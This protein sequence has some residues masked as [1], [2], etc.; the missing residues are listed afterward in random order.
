MT[1]ESA[2]VKAAGAFVPLFW[3]MGL[4]NYNR[5]RG[6]RD[7]D[8]RIRST[9]ALFILGLATFAASLSATLGLMDAFDGGTN[10]QAHSDCSPH[11]MAAA[12]P[13]CAVFLFF[14]CMDLWLDHQQEPH[15]APS[16]TKVACLTLLILSLVL[17]MGSEGR[18]SLSN[19]VVVF[20]PN[21][22]NLFQTLIG[23]ILM[24]LAKRTELKGTFKRQKR[25]NSSLTNSCSI[26]A[27]H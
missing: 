4:C 27:L 16:W 25:D 2:L 21:P 6:C 3:M 26:T 13:H 17:V 14:L 11:K 7:P 19:L 15:K 12:R 22:C 9:S 24:V 10:Q 18:S 1:S 20:S 8:L 23:L 5:A